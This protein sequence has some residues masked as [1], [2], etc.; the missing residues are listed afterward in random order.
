MEYVIFMDSLIMECPYAMIGEKE[1]MN[2]MDRVSVVLF[3]FL[4]VIGFISI[5]LRCF[6]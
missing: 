1:E 4:I 3:L 2:S 5:F 6:K